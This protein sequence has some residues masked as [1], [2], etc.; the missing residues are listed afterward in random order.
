MIL[1]STYKERIDFTHDILAAYSALDHRTT[2]ELGR[3]EVQSSFRRLLY[4]LSALVMLHGVEASKS[5]LIQLASGSGGDDPVWVISN[6]L[7]RGRADSPVELTGELQQELVHFSRIVDVGA[8]GLGHADSARAISRLHNSVR[9]PE[10]MKVLSEL[11]IVARSRLIQRGSSIEAPSRN[12]SK[13]DERDLGRMATIIAAPDDCGHAA[14]IECSRRR[15]RRELGYYFHNLLS[16]LTASEASAVLWAY[17]HEEAPLEYVSFTVVSE[18]VEA[19]NALTWEYSGFDKDQDPM[20]DCFDS[21]PL[22]RTLL[23][24]MSLPIGRA[25]I[26]NDI[27]SE[28]SGEFTIKLQSEALLCSLTI[29]PEPEKRPAELQAMAE[30]CVPLWDDYKGPEVVSIECG[31]IHLDREI[32]VDQEAGVTIGREIYQHIRRGQERVPSLTPMMDDDHVMVKLSPRE[33]AE[34]LRRFLPGRHFYLIPE[35][36]PIIR[37]IAA[38]LYARIKLLGLDESLALRGGNQFIL[39]ENGNYCEIIEDISGTCTTGCVFFE[40]ALL[41]YRC[42]PGEF[43]AY[44]RERFSLDGDVHAVA[45]EL[46][47]M[48]ISHDEKVRILG[49]FYDRFSE[50]T[51][52]HRPDAG[53]SELVYSILGSAGEQWGHLNVLEDYYEVQQEKVRALI[54]LLKLPFTL[55]SLHFNV[56]TGRLELVW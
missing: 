20:Q 26:V 48:D 18:A 42:A 36:S 1:S 52:I 47:T 56:A 50:V 27:H 24:E 11:M 21:L 40:T 17:I 5:M 10:S 45:A 39:L 37:S 44:F 49:E 54:S 29:T 41:A 46:L 8:L 28:E 51:E 12:P 16:Y 22:R 9:L 15:L 32:D 13:Y 38:V 34:F 2:A 35:S 6:F 19:C 30:R 4:R 25:T 33:Y 43:D 23:G 3:L 7:E 14:V 55:I 53:V 31:H